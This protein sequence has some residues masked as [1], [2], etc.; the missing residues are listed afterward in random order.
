MSNTRYLS[1]ERQT[2]PKI[3]INNIIISTYMH[4]KLHIKI[5]ILMEYMQKY[6]YIQIRY[7]RAKYAYV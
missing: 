4:I 1:S 2:C 3:S 6:T 5:D 7:L